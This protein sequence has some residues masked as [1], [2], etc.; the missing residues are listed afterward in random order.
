MGWR[1]KGE[2]EP[3][4]VDHWRGRRNRR[5]RSAQNG[6]RWDHVAPPVR[7]DGWGTGVRV[8]AIIISPL[9]RQ[10]KVDHREYETVSILKFLESRFN[11]PPLAARDT[12][13]AVND[14]VDAFTE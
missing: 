14:L 9:A 12:D 5:G 3:N 2:H 11:L 4:C 10:G 13:P 7:N 8:P 6:G 1:K